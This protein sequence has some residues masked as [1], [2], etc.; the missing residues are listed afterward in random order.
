MLLRK[1]TSYSGEVFRAKMTF[2]PRKLG[3][4]AGLVLWWSQY[5]YATVGLTASADPG[6]GAEKTV[7]VRTPTGRPGEMTVEN[8]DITLCLLTC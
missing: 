1:Q 2:N 7:I 3:Y 8:P 5:S 6:L 4:E